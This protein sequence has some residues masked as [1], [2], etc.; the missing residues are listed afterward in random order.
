M[1]PVLSRFS[2]KIQIGSLVAL[3]GLILAGL[4]GV[5]LVGGGITRNAAAIAAREE[6]I[7]ERATALD[8]ALLQS[9][10]QEKEFLLR[11]DGALID[12]HDRALDA[13]RAALDAIGAALPANDPR[14]NEVATVRKD[15]GAYA[16]LFKTL[17]D[18]QRRVGL[19]E[20]D[21][22]MGKLRGSIHAVEDSLNAHDELHLAVLM[23]MMRRHEKDFFARLDAKYVD[24][25]N[26]RM[27]EFRQTIGASAMPKAAR[28]QIL[29]RMEDYQ[30]DFKAASADVLVVAATAQQLN[31]AY[32]AIQPAA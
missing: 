16:A 17:A 2:L 12:D 15:L 28:P 6:L 11:R 18:G 7:G 30:R 4:L 8:L 25:F 9:R 32:L 31:E 5:Q 29:A 14:Q 3:A 24:E 19:D 10:S 22:L 27:G 21:G 13:A 23:L 1:Q 20:N 26:K